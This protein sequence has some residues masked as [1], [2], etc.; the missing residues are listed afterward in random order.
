MHLGV[1]LKDTTSWMVRFGVIPIKEIIPK[2]K[3]KCIPTVCI[4]IK[5]EK[6]GPMWV[7]FLKKKWFKAKAPQGT[8]QMS[9]RGYQGNHEVLPGLGALRGVDPSA[10]LRGDSEKVLRA[11]G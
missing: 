3:Q 10:W 8:E 5:Q 9:A 6:P 1:P 7:P 2:K 11:G 4:P